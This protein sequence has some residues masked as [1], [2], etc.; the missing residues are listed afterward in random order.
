VAV[1]D[2]AGRL[3]GIVHREGSGWQPDIVFHQE[4]E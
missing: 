2:T 3:R 4:S 1:I